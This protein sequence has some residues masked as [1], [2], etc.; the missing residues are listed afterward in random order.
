ME[1]FRLL[2]AFFTGTLFYVIMAVVGGRDGIWAAS[3]M[4]EQKQVLSAHVAEIEKTNNELTLEK[5]ALQ[6]DSDVIAAYAR[7]LGYVG[8]GEK[9]VKITGMP[10]RE[11]RIFDPGT[12]IHHEE[13]KYIPEAVCKISGLVIALLVY[14]V[15]VLYDVQ[16]GVLVIRM[17]FSR[18]FSSAGSGEFAIYDAK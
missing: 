12:V 14:L 6:K 2:A 1:R 17:P 18:K 7:K 10:S 13:A 3:Q 4:R 8:D 11:T 16:R 15:L 9:L 5:I